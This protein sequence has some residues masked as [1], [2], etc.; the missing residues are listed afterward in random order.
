[1]TLDNWEEI[2][3]RVRSCFPHSGFS[4]R[5]PQDICPGLAVGAELVF[6]RACEAL[7]ALPQGEAAHGHLLQLDRDWLSVTAYKFYA[8]EILIEL[9]LNPYDSGLCYR[10]TWPFHSQELQLRHGSW[11]NAIQ[12]GCSGPQRDVLKD[13][14]HYYVQQRPGKYAICWKEFWDELA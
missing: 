3:D 14:M 4:P 10:P 1:M 8:Q 2:A 11:L 6:W 13:I 9:K 5:L 12:A 7:V